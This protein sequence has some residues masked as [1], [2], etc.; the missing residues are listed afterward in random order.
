MKTLRWAFYAC[1]ASFAIGLP[2]DEGEPAAEPTRK[3]SAS[4]P[5]GATSGRFRP[6]D[7][8]GPLRAVAK[9]ECNQ[10]E[11]YPRVRFIVTNGR[12]RWSKSVPGS[13]ATAASALTQSQDS[14]GRTDVACWLD[15]VGCLPHRVR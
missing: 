12:G 9:V 11:L 4:E 3:V 1:S 15:G 13:C 10:G 14:Q 8:D 5:V 7:R 2:Q 6:P